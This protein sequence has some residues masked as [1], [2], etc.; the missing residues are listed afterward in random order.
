MM[1]LML[2]TNLKP[3]PKLKRETDLTPNLD[4]KLKPEKKDVAGPLHDFFEV[5]ERTYKTND[6][7][8]NVELK[9]IS[10][11]FPEPWTEGMEVGYYGGCCEPGFYLELI[12]ADGDIV[13]RYETNV[14]YSRHELTA[15]A[16]LNEGETA[17]LGFSVN[18]SENAVGFRIGSSFKVHPLENEEEADEE[19]TPVEVD[20]V[21]EDIKNQFSTSSATLQEN[22]RQTV[23][24]TDTD[25]D[26]EE[27]TED[28][29]NSAEEKSTWQKVKEKTKNA[30]HKTKEFT[31]NTYQKAKRKV[32]N[33]LNGD[34][35]D[36]DEDYEEE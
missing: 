11:G 12:D 4:Q 24:E 36:Y 18:G 1:K 22:G 34:D 14:V 35:D 25:A 7:V 28:T 29:E 5:V 16:E 32:K 27:Q 9:R 3:E 19:E 17:V 20:N 15:L 21:D 10:E 8:L 31:K 26:E 23:N 30:Y 6:G 13:D 33:W 2:K